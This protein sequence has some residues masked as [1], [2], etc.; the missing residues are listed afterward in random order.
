MSQEDASAALLELH[1]VMND[2]DGISADAINFYNGNN[3][4]KED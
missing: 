3:G 2:S 4:E 1:K